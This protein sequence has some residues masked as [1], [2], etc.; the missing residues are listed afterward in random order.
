MSNY[1]DFPLPEDFFDDFKDFADDF[2]LIRDDEY[3]SKVKGFFKHEK[4]EIRIDSQIKIFK[5]DILYHISSGT[6]YYVKTAIPD[7][8]ANKNYG[9]VVKYVEN[10]ELLKEKVKEEKAVFNIGS[11]GNNA[12][13]GTQNMATI[14]AQ[15]S[16][17]TPL[18]QLKE[19][20]NSKPA[21]DKELLNKLLNRLEIIEEDNQ[22]VSKGTLAK[23]SDLL[24]KHSDIAIAV[25]SFLTR[26]LS[27]S[28]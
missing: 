23:F 1:N 16:V 10:P 3:I 24:A 6:N 2:K 22:P 20:I 7:Y 27:E 15:N 12:I 21:E 17:N 8:F 9:T 25:G 4:S 11:I 26:W 28:K 18:E 13:I 14:I 5:G 19:L